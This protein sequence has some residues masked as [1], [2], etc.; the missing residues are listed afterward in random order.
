MSQDAP[1]VADAAHNASE[2]PRQRQLALVILAVIGVVGTLYFARGFLVPLL[3][4]IL[5]S[6][7]LSPLVNRLHSR[8]LPRPL[9]AALVLAL[10]TGG[11]SWVAYA[12]S[13]QAAV[14]IEKLPEAAR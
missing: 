7:T 8:R 9:A 6:Y 11:T 3:I 4:G 5:A 13:G 14:M 12:V 1:P 10:L 2:R